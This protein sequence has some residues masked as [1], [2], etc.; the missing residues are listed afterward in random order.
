MTITFAQYK[1][2]ADRI[3]RGAP[4]ACDESI[5]DAYDNQPQT[6]QGKP[7]RSV[8]DLPIASAMW[9]ADKGVK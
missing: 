8:F 4:L 9:R 7:P 3:R 5:C 2:S 6:S 1:E